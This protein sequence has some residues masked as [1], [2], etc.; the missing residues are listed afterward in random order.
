[1][2]SKMFPK[3]SEWRKWDLHIHT[4]ASFHWNDG[5][6][7]RDMT[8]VTDKDAALQRMVEKI[9]QS[10]IAVFGIMDYWTFEGY[11]SLK[12]YLQG[13]AVTLTKRVFPGME[14]RI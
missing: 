7:F 12:A 4:P 3:G 6:R 2:N 9:E 13:N 1:M 11:L 5:L 14:L 10:D 8:L